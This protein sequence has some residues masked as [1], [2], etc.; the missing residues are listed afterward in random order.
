MPGLRALLRLSHIASRRSTNCRRRVDH[1]TAAYFREQ[2][3]LAA[4]QAKAWLPRSARRAPIQDARHHPLLRRSLGCAPGEYA[5]VI[6]D[7]RWDAGAVLETANMQKQADGGW[8]VVGLQRAA[9]QTLRE[10]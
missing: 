3:E 4:W 5:V 6:H 7:S 1:T 10:G 8:P 2:E 9:A